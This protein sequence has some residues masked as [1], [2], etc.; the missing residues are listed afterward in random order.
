MGNHAI[1]DAP[2]AAIL[3]TVQSYIA[4][5]RAKM[6]DYPALNRLTDGSESSDRDIARAMLLAVDDYNTTPPLLDAATLVAF[7]SK[8]LLVRA[9][10]IQ[11]LE[12]LVLLQARN[13]L[14]YADGQTQIATENPQ[15]YQ[16]IISQLKAEYEAKKFKFKQAKNLSDALGVQVGV[17]SEYLLINDWLDT[18]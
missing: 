17:S 4:L 12:E 11:L 9:T 1:A 5:V 15:L 2:N 14:P 16:G 18:L 6:R 10:I 3:Q 7:P 8:D 13:L